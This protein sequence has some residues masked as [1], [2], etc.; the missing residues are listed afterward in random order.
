MGVMMMAVVTVRSHR[1]QVTIGGA[2][3]S[4]TF[5][6]TCNLFFDDADRKCEFNERFTNVAMKKLMIPLSQA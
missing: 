2:K 5:S 1:I 4:T 3:P 6:D